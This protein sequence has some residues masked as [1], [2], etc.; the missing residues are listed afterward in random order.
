MQ[1]LSAPHAQRAAMQVRGRCAA[2]SRRQARVI[3]S[4]RTYLREGTRRPQPSWC[5]AA[6]WSSVRAASPG[7]RGRGGG[8]GGP[9]AATAVGGFCGRRHGARGRRGHHVPHHRRQDAHGDDRR[10]R[11]LRG[12]SL[13][14]P[15]LRRAALW[16]ACKHTWH[17]ETV[18]HEA[19]QEVS[20][21]VQS[22]G[23]CVP[24]AYDSTRAWQWPL[25]ARPCTL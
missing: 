15:P 13:A 14:R 22:F 11:A 8:Q 9:A 2:G 23:C 25:L 16:R 7:R 4:V 3:F 21:K 18:W 19:M 17:D 24:K 1:E 10:Q 20:M 6:W 5:E 12:A